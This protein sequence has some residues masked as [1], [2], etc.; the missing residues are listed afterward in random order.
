MRRTCHR[1]LPEEKRDSS[2]PSTVKNRGTTSVTDIGHQKGDPHSVTVGVDL[3][4]TG[5]RIVALTCD[6]NVR[7]SRSVPT[8]GG[9]VTE[10]IRHIEV[11]AA[12]AELLAVGIGASG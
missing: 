8:S 7:R 5:T 10:L 6:G 4:G 3:G 12:N 1:H 2:Y 11:V 9:S